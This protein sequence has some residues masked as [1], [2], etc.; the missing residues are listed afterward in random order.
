MEEQK[1][2]SKRV[3]RPIKSKVVIK[4]DNGLAELKWTA[5]L[6]ISTDHGLAEGGEEALHVEHER[7]EVSRAE[8]AGLHEAAAVE[9]DQA[10]GAV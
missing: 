8:R 3:D 4:K 7:D 6:L 10:S 1:K 9:E 2:G 5:D